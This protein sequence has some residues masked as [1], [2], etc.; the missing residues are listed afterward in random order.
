MKHSLLLLLVLIITFSCDQ[1]TD[2][3]TINGELRGDFAEGTQVFLKKTG[4]NGQPV[5]L[6]TTLLEN[7]KF[8]FKGAST[9][10]DLH[11]IFVGEAPGYTAIV[12]ENGTINFSAQ[13]DSLGFAKV[14]GTLQN[15]VFYSY[16]EESREL[17]QQARSIQEDMQKAGGAAG[18]EGTIAALN[19]EMQELQDEYKTFEIDFIKNNPD[20]LISALLLDRTIAM[21]TA[22]IDE[23][24]AM[25]DGLSQEI[26]DTNPGKKVLELLVK[27]REAEEANKTTAVG[28]KAP[29]FSGP[30]PDGEV[31]A[32]KDVMGKVTLIDFWAAWCKPCRAENPNIV[33]VYEKYH[34][35][36]LNVIGVSLDRSAEAWK[37]AILD[38]GLDWQQISNVAYFD[39]PIAKMYNV[40]AIPAAFLLDENGV[41]VAK[42]LRGPAL[43]AKVSELLD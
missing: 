11:Y 7:G 41:I 3:Y 23:V 38:D 39:D 19:D 8:Q 16:L 43:E 30:N 42:N 5:E 34:D 35:K 27:K 37:K 40:K 29:E 28:A 12:V 10:P 31:L 26:K 20:A 6:D 24:Q 36:G 15:E 32:L 14:D 33:S 9:A 21:N 18:G 25:Y 22:E 2:G 17:S 1:N 4:D 13:K